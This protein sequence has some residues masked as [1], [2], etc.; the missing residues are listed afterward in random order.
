MDSHYTYAPVYAPTQPPE[1]R[2]SFNPLSVSQSLGQ[3]LP[4]FTTTLPPLSTSYLPFTNDHSAQ[5]AATTSSA[6]TPNSSTANGLYTP[7]PGYPRQASLQYPNQQQIPRSF[8]SSQEYQSPDNHAATYR[9][10]IPPASHH[11]RLA[12]IRPMPLGGLGDQP[13]LA[14]APGSSSQAAFTHMPIPTQT[15]PTH[16]V[17]SQGRRGILPCANGRPIAVANA[18][19]TKSSTANLKKDPNDGK[20]PCDHCNKRYLHAKHLKR[21]LLRRKLETLL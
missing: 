1:S 21:H 19:T 13:S 3:T 2:Q 4:A 15:E 18:G 17:G 20:W 11:S 5:G 8:Q 9:P 14:A 6:Y 12:D 16:V 10:Y 7:F